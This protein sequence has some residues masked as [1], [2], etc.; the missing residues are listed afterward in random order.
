MELKFHE[1]IA[2]ILHYLLLASGYIG[3]FLW[4]WIKL[5][6]GEVL[7]CVLGFVLVHFWSYV[8]DILKRKRATERIER[9]EI[10]CNSCKYKQEND[11]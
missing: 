9:Q 4:V 3:L 10:K 11:K 7:V 8:H 1:R 6:H 2:V 5:E